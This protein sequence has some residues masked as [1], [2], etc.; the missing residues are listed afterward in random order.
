MVFF[1]LH[2]DLPP[3]LPLTEKAH[4]QGV[5]VRKH[6]LHCL[7]EQ[8]WIQVFSCSDLSIKTL[9]IVLGRLQLEESL[10]CGKERCWPRHQSLLCLD[11]RS[12]LRHL[13]KLSN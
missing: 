11:S 10:L 4:T 8:P 13:C 3:A 9:M 6:M 12:H 1:R 2:I 7:C 5:V